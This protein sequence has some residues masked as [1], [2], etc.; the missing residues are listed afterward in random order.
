MSDQ[1]VKAYLNL[2][3]VM[4]NLEDLVEYDPVAQSI[5]RNWKVSIQFAVVHGPAVRIVFEKGRCRVT[6]GFRLNSDILL[7]FASGAHLNEAMENRGIPILT[8]GLTRLPFLLKEFPKLTR[9]ME[10][11]LKPAAGAVE[12]PAFLALHTRLLLQT[13][14]FAAAV[15]SLRDPKSKLA[16]SRIRDGM[17]ALKV[18]PS[19]PGVLLESRKGTLKASRGM[20]PRP[21]AC[22]EFRDLATAQRFLSGAIDPFTAIALGEVEI[23]GQTPMLDSLNLILDRVEHYLK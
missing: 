15:L 7:L 4:L 1:L 22:L 3:A 18:L 20:S 19:G 13:V 10:E 5:C 14:G 17:V 23:R 6:P 21:T 12:D 11:V 2:H 8:R 9:R 16:A